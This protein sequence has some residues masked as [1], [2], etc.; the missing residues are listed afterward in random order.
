[1]SR[2]VTVCCFAMSSNYQIDFSTLKF[3]VLDLAE[4]VEE[5]EEEDYVDDHAFTKVRFQPTTMTH[6]RTDS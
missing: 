6:L 3:P 1:M 4:E 5:E 2:V